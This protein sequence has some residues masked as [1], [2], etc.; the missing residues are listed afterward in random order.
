MKKKPVRKTCEYGHT[1]Y[2]SS[3][4]P[5]CPVCEAENKPDSGFLSLLSSPARNALVHE[6]ITTLE[7]LAG[8]TEKEVLSIH[9][10]GPASMP[11][12]HEVLKEKNLQFKK[13]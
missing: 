11:A 7:K 12:L 3:D 2:E 6:G 5:S 9:G 13:S 4:C 10:I 1:Y 8:F